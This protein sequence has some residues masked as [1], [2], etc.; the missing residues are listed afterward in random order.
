[1]VTGTTTGGLEAAGRPVST[2]RPPTGKKKFIIHQGI[3]NIQF[4]NK[5]YLMCHILC[6]IISVSSPPSSQYDLAEMQEW[7][8][9]F[10]QASKCKYLMMIPTF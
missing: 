10:V 1:M 7:G 2:A 8:L 3:A 4:L 6:L 9:R 5:N